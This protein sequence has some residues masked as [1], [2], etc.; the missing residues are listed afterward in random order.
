MSYLV[1]GPTFRGKFNAEKATELG[2]PK[3]KIR[4][5]LA[6]G[7]SITFDVKVGDEIIQRTVRAEDVVAQPEKPSVRVYILAA[8][9]PLG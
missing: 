7:E 1:V 8:S 6:R 2:V 3:G 4:S 5:L 9:Q